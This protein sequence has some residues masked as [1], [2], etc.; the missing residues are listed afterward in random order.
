[1]PAENR[2]AAQ[3]ATAVPQCFRGSQDHCNRLNSP[4]FKTFS[5]SV[6]DSISAGV[7]PAIR[8]LMRYLSAR[9]FEIAMWADRTIKKK[10][11]IDTPLVPEP[12]A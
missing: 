6:V 7:C 11:R 3:N 9:C 10:D 12:S 1:M 4:E 5:G 2:S 8:Q